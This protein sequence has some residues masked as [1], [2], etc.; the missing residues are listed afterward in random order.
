MCHPVRSQRVRPQGHPGCVGRK[1]AIGLA[2]R[3]RGDERVALGRGPRP[4]SS[5]DADVD[6]MGLRGRK[7]PDETLDQQNGRKDEEQGERPDYRT[8]YERIRFIARFIADRLAASLLACSM[9]FACFGSFLIEYKEGN[10]TLFTVY[11]PLTIAITVCS[12]WLAMKHHLFDYLWYRAV[13]GASITLF[14]VFSILQYAAVYRE[15]GLLDAGVTKNDHWTCIY[16]SVVTWTTL[17]YGDVVPTQGARMVAASEALVGSLTHAAFI[18]LI[19]NLFR[20][21]GQ[22]RKSA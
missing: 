20:P 9:F 1:L 21:L 17:G 5:R 6:R 10:P 8:A 15:L 16:F 7:V 13:L 14:A 4:P 22:T 12:L 2:P 3:E 19:A 11:L 18:G